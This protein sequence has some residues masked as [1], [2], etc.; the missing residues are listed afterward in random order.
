MLLGCLV[1]FLDSHLVTNILYCQELESMR[2]TVVSRI[3]YQ[4]VMMRADPGTN[5]SGVKRGS[6][7]L[8]I[9]SA[10]TFTSNGRWLESSSSKGTV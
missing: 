4:V 10:P 2:D 6:Y 7:E 9:S 5:G 8:H 1:R 3:T